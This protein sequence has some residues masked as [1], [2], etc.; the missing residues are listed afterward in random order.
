M[1]F[2]RLTRPSVALD[3]LA[4]ERSAEL[5]FVPFLD[6]FHPVPAGSYQRLPLDFSDARGLNGT[7]IRE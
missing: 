5:L 2:S 7:M 4:R 1:M 6:S 3:P